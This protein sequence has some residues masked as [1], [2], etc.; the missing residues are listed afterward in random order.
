[1]NYIVNIDAE[2]VFR[3]VSDAGD[4]GEI[5]AAFTYTPDAERFWES[6]SEDR[7][8]YVRPFDVAKD[9]SCDEPIVVF[10]HVVR[11]DDPYSHAEALTQK[12]ADKWLTEWK[13]PAQ[14]KH[15]AAGRRYQEVL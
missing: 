1:M 15:E 5:K 14:A 2:V 7:R 9:G 13:T 8:R 10:T 12:S 6:M 4:V 3:F 11:R